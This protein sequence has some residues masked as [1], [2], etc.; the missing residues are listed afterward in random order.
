MNTYTPDEVMKLK[1]ENDMVVVMFYATV[2]N[3]SIRISCSGVLIVNGLHHPFNKL[4]IHLRICRFC[5]CETLIFS[6]RIKFGRVNC[7]E[8]GQFCKKNYV[9]GYP[10]LSFF[11][12][13]KEIGV[14]YE[15]PRDAP[16]I[17]SY[18]AYILGRNTRL[19]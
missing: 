12:P 14:P 10:S 9:F 15:G 6:P 5:T 7:V 3:C 13:D 1:G 4:P 18:I 16:H 17:V 2:V 11:I 8:Y 19:G